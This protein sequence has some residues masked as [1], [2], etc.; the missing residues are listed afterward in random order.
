M[1]GGHL[2]N[3]LGR[4]QTAGGVQVHVQV[5]V[6]VCVRGGGGRRREEERKGVTGQVGCGI[7]EV[8][9]AGGWNYGTHTHTRNTKHTTCPHSI[10]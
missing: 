2:D 5:H 8:Y 7:A 1:R 3:L 6:R 10:E 4:G 9:D